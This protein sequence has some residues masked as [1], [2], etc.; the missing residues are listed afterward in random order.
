M[1][2]CNFLFIL[3]KDE[4]VTGNIVQFSTQITY[5]FPSGCNTDIEDPTTVAYAEMRLAV[6]MQVRRIH[7][8]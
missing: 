7:R 4:A 5:T 2:V 8:L 6:I 1:I 3:E